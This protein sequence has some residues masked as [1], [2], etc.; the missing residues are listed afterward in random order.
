MVLMNR[1]LLSQESVEVTH[2][3]KVTRTTVFSN[4]F[5]ALHARPEQYFQFKEGRVPFAFANRSDLI[6]EVFYDSHD[7]NWLVQVANSVED[8][9]EGLNSGDRIFIPRL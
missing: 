1:K 9:F 4:I 2:R 6:A 8:P 5:E 3:G 7:L